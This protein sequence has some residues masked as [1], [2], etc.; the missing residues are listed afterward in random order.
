[1]FAVIFEVQPKPDRRDDYLGLAR[2]L[3]PEIEKIDGFLDNE[4]F[5]SERTAGRLL[6]LSTWRDE[7]SV[8]RWR[9]LGIHHQVQATGRRE[10]FSG[11]HLRVGE[12]IADTHPPAGHSLRQDRL[13][14][15][16]IGAAKF[17]TII[18]AWPLPGQ[19][20]ES[21]L[22]QPATGHGG[23]V[24]RDLFASITT[25]GKRLLLLS[26]RDEAA[27]GW[28][29]EC[30]A[31]GA[32]RHRQVRIIRDYG[33]FDRREAPQWHAPVPPADQAG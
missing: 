3:R 5:T 21:K 17:C 28:T 25:Q 6:S 27:A 11:Y 33:M 20:G 14:A 30:R 8:I 31:A 7:K 2:L 24:D 13:D 1:M 23:P 18:E 22:A 4:R 16:E 32:W 15:T 26:W 9:T 12:I 10:I 29:P 19:T